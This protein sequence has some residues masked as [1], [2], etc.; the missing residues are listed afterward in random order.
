MR[1]LSISVLGDGGWGTTLAILLSR[2]GF[3]VSLWGAFQQ[4]AAYL[5]K[6]RINSKFLPGIKIPSDINIISD[7]SVAIEGKDLIIFAIPSEYLRSILEKIKKFDYPKGAKYLSV[8]KGIE[9]SSL[10]RIS[11]IINE[12]IG[13]VSLAVLSG[14]TIAHE[15][16]KGIPT[17]AVVASYD[18]NLRDSLQNILMTESFRVYTN[19]DVIGVELGGSL[20][21]I[22]AIA[23]GISDG[24]GFGTNTKAAL[25]SRGL[26]EISRLGLAMGATHKTFYGLTGLGDLVT[27]CSS[28]YSRNRFVGEQIG[29]GRTFKQIKAHMQMVAEGVPTTKSAHALSLKYKVDMP[30][31]KEI[32]TVLYKNKSPKAAV[33]DLM[34]RQKKDE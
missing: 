25:L 17:A 14:P 15:V 30:I 24:L 29:R 7:L 34:T 31:T 6:K 9:I 11:E 32:Y 28:P 13:A 4:Y 2:K 20:K 10:K 12:E 22:I 27:T 1:K 8:I 26:V 23:C 16:A 18:K 33:R 3:K 19:N 21:N 5:D